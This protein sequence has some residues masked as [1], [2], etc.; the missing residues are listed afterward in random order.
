MASVRREDLFEV[1]L[2]DE[3]F[4]LYGGEDEYLGYVLWKA[5]VRLVFAPEARATHLRTPS[6]ASYAHRY[7]EY[8]MSSLPVM[9]EKCPDYIRDQLPSLLLPLADRI[10]S[11]YSANG[12]R[13]EYPLRIRVGAMALHAALNPVFVYMLE[14]WVAAT[15]R[16][17]PLYF[18]GSI[19]L[20]Q[21]AWLMQG[22]RR[23]LR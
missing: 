14:K 7:R 5:G 4:R 8:G 11:E 2:Y 9:L 15:D 16:V 10:A 20:L 17:A 22:L 6:L 1:G 3:T 13:R 21:L 18:S 12:A 19:R 23:R